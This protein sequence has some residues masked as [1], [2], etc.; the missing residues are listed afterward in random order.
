MLQV[1]NPDLSLNVT[2]CPFY[3][4]AFLQNQYPLVSSISLSVKPDSETISKIRVVLTADP[5]V[6][7]VVSWELDFLEAGTSS[8]LLNKSV[9]ISSEYL[10]GLTEQIEVLL[11]F[12]IFSGDELLNT[13]HHS[14]NLMPKNQWAG[15]DGMP[16]LLAAFCM[17]NSEFSEELVR[18]VAETLLA[19]GL[20]PQIDGYQSKTRDKP[21]QMLSALWNVIKSKQLSYVNPSPTFA[22]KGQRIRL[23]D[24]IK[25]TPNAACLDMAMLFASVIERM[26]LNPVVLI[27]R[28]HAFVGAWLIDQ[29]SQYVTNDDPMDLRKKISNQDL[30][31]F[32]T[33]LAALG[34]TANFSQAVDSG[35]LLLSE[36]EE[37]DFVFALDIKQARK[38]EI[39]PIPTHEK[40]S[41]DTISQDLNVIQPIA[42]TPVLPPV[43]LEELVND[44][45]NA[46]TRVDTWKRKLLDLTKRNKLLNLSSNAVALKLFCPDL[47]LLEDK[48]AAGETFIIKSSDQTP[49]SDVQRDQ[50]IFKFETGN[51]LQLT[52]AKEQLL[53][54]AVISHDVSIK[55]E[56]QL[57]SLFRKTKNDLEEGGSNT[58]FL[59]IGMLKWKETHN[60]TRSYKAPL[61]LLPVELIRQSARSKI[62]LKQLK[63]EEPIFNSTLIQFLQQDFEINL[64]QFRNVLPTDHSGVDINAIWTIVRQK[65]DDSPGFEVTE[66]LVLSNFSFAKYLM[67]K[68]LQ[69]RVDQLK[70]N[71]FVNHMVERPTEVYAQSLS[72]VDQDQVDK[73]IKPAEIYAPLNADSSQMVA[74]EASG[75]PQDFVMEGPPGTGKSETIANIIC[76]NIALGKKVLFVA[77]KMAALNVVYK[78]LKKVGVSHLCL[79]LHSS[80][81]NKSAV[82]GQLRAAWTEREKADQTDW[83]QSAEK[84]YEL[85]THLNKYVQELH[86]PQNFGVSARSAISRTS[87]FDQLHRQNVSWGAS[88]ESAPVKDRAEL[89]V[90]YNDIKSLGIA[91]EDIKDVEIQELDFIN[92]L[93]WSNSWQSE[94]VLASKDLATQIRAIKDFLNRLL[95]QLELKAIGGFKLIA[96]INS[97]EFTLFIRDIT[98]TKTGLIFS[99]RSKQLISEL[100]ELYERKR[101]FDKAIVGVID[102]PTIT[103]I[104]D[105]PWQKWYLRLQELEAKSFIGSFFG[106]RTLKKEIL[107]SGVFNFSEL[108][109]IS[110][111]ARAQNIVKEND[112]LPE[113]FMSDKIWQGWGMSSSD[114]LERID[115]IERNV[116]R[117]LTFIQDLKAP[118]AETL[119]TL[120]N[121]FDD[122]WDFIETNSELRSL[123]AD[124]DLRSGK[125]AIAVENFERLSNSTLSLNSECLEILEKLDKLG[126]NAVKLNAWCRWLDAKNVCMQYQLPEIVD[127]LENKLIDPDNLIEVT[128]T[129][130]MRWLAPKLLDK[131]QTLRT[132]SGSQ[133]NALI[134]DFRDLDK[135]VADTTSKFIIAKTASNVP[136]PGSREQAPEFGVLSRELQKK[137]RHKPVRQLVEQMGSRLLDLTP[138]MLMSPLSVAQYLPADFN[139][140]DLIVFDEASQI[141]VWDAVGAIARAKNAIIVGDPKQMPPTNFFGRGAADDSDEADLESILDQALGSGIKHHRLTGHYR[142]R[143]E[144]LIAFSNSHYYENS[145][146]TFPSA[147]TKE[148]AVSFHKVNGVYS[149]GKGRNNPIEA[150]A[151]AK[152]VYRRLKHPKLQKL[153]IGIVALN[154]EQ[155]RIIEDELDTFRR[156]DSSIERF[157]QEGYDIDPVFIKNLESVQGDERDVI[158]LSIG[159][160]PTEPGANNMSMNFGPLNK[161]GGERRLNVA[162]TRATTE[163]MLFASFG[164]ELID[165]SRTKATAIQHLKTF[166]EFAEKGPIA[167]SQAA[168]TRH[169]IDQFDSDFESAV[170][171]KLRAKGWNVVSQVG[172]GK[173]RIDL[174][175]VHPEKPGVYLAGIECD[176]ATYHSSPSAR[177]RDRVRQI[178]LEGLGWKIVRLWSTDYF[179]DSDGSVEKIHTQLEEILANY[180]EDLEEDE[181]VV[182][183]IVDGLLAPSTLNKEN[184]FQPQSSD[185][186]RGLCEEFLS[187]MNGISL[188]ALSDEIAK[189]VGIGR[190]SSKFNERILS[191]IK[192]W[193]GISKK[194]K[195]DPTVWLNKQSIVDLIEWRG[196]APAG[197]VRTW[198]E[199]SYHEQLGV[200]KYALTQNRHSPALAIKE[201]FNLSRLTKSTEVEFLGWVAN[202]KKLK[203]STNKN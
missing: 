199:I 38:R 105:L 68:D 127:A 63:D 179:L 108:N 65:I 42:A 203:E 41:D 131:S 43:K 59:S 139:E 71:P 96:L 56:K 103:Q 197:V 40:S 159:Y 19:S 54:N 116:D 66:E 180:E 23:P 9:R 146:V 150:A 75:H 186:L 124:Y 91:F 140:F 76:H 115:F 155:A 123:L 89:D 69:D 148:S 200:A 67:W 39:R 95:G 20:P 119:S 34:S 134:N 170:A 176:G 196:L 188:S 22:T 88:I 13:L 154:N 57:L 172:V 94:V 90:L 74:I 109:D 4:A 73:K 114:L 147:E 136:D 99:G 104:S 142:S 137:S 16:E 178:I 110:A 144:S 101:Q 141:T 158:I 126:P 18:S 121:Q 100:R 46:E 44:D 135:Y 130:I 15:F 145:L 37:K 183:P 48:L 191:I 192:P 93:D 12:E 83:V 149:K 1:N 190:V 35:E 64:N 86:A 152:E 53:D 77:E 173:F 168:S 153:S 97:E 62:K 202:Y 25:R 24:D 5:E 187:N 160:G 106:K 80:K 33:T 21:H 8:V 198:K 85:R 122:Q 107:S 27:T 31:V 81:S 195:K 184:F 133:H 72:F 26:G 78:R 151:V 185:A 125:L 177:D 161:E 30:I 79:E 182:E 138:C 128:K 36:D 84:L 51:N 163:V 52:Y 92:H 169:G 112:N 143:H 162:I 174:G 82:L 132:F 10:S 165:L 70:E 193:A 118:I 28:E 2:V 61:I 156:K 167:L 29:C 98:A 111:I 11:K 171:F 17:P 49:F 50:K 87:R 58:L 129:A 6:I 189:S 164:A 60:S 102:S 7:D 3:S 113:E 55:T 120:K 194:S 175:V 166:F 45:E 47:P 117:V 201:M 157:F 14:T 32:E 181:V